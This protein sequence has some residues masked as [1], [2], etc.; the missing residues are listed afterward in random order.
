MNI[1]VH[2]AQ[3]LAKLPPLSTTVALARAQKRH[4]QNFLVDESLCHTIA[5]AVPAGVAVREIGPGPGGL[6][7][8]LLAA[9]H[10]VEAIDID[11]EMLALLRP[12]EEAFPAQL[13]LHQADATRLPPI[14]QPTFVVG[15]LP[16]HVATR[17]W[18][19]WL[20]APQYILGMVLMF[21]AEVA[22]RLIA[23]PRTKAYGRLSVISQ[24]LFDIEPWL[25]LSAAQFVPAPKVDALVIRALPKADLANRLQDFSALSRWTKLAF[26]RPRK[27][28]GAGLKGQLTQHQDILARAGIDAQQRPEELSVKQFWHLAKSHPL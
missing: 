13:T 15:N 12:L 3:A 25:T 8:A 5:S 17:L 14:A 18:T 26:T 2:T 21:Q 6:T 24:F 7:R 19:D 4:G 1:P 20:A 28:L 10:H 22:Q 9:N 23:T 11:A 27:T 16:F